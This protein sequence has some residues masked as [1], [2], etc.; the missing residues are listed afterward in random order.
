MQR[1]KDWRVF[2]PVLLLFR[3]VCRFH[4]G[5]RVE[6]H[7]AL[8]HAARFHEN[9][10]E[11]DS[12]V[13]IGKRRLKLHSTQQQQKIWRRQ[14]ARKTRCL[15]FLKYQRPMRALTTTKTR[16][17]ITTG[18][19]TAIRLTLQLAPTNI[20]LHWHTSGAMHSPFSHAGLNIRKTWYGTITKRKALTCKWQIHNRSP[21]IPH[22][23]DKR[24]D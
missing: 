17:L 5:H 11:I 21:S 3:V 2:L 6:Q 18:R 7:A 24:P 16:T 20:E 1:K 9:V 4:R 13:E 23:T 12:P 8:S 10:F 14:T 19:T 15:Y 22:C